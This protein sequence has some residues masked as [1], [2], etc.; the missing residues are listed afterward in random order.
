MTQARLLYAGRLE[1]L[2]ANLIDTLILVVPSVA[3]ARLLHGNDGLSLLAAFLCN[4]TYYTAFTGSRWQA[5]PGKRL[6][7][8]YVIHA[9]GRPMTH[10]DALERFLAYI[11]PS[12]P[13][14]VSFLDQNAAAILV[15]WLSIFWFAPILF[16]P[17]RVGVHDRLCHTRVIVGRVG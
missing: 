11:M 10:R 13:I 14:Y 9:N 2:F 8:I 4:L 5:T 16:T 1:R 7:N 17:D 12:L 3:L 15:V 6:L